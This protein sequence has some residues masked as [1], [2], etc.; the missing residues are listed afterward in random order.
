MGRT[1]LRPPFQVLSGDSID[2]NDSVSQIESSLLGDTTRGIASV[3]SQLRDIAEAAGEIIAD[4]TLFENPLPDPPETVRLIEAAWAQAQ[5]DLDKYGNRTHSTERWVSMFLGKNCRRADKIQLRGVQSGTHSQLI[6]DCKR[7]ILG[8]Y[9]LD[10]L[11]AP[12]LAISVQHLL[13]K[14]RFTCT[15]EK[16]EVSLPYS[17]HADN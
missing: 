4:H 6:Y 3:P 15:R 8:L 1:P 16:R 5:D 14:D 2:P 13:E 9:Q 11:S 7:S 10:S 12:E 17:R